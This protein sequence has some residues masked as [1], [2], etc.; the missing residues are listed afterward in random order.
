MFNNWNNRVLGK[1]K[2]V[3]FALTLCFF[4]ISFGA[5]ADEFSITPGDELRIFIP[6]LQ[7][8]EQLY[9]VGHQG[10]IDLGI[11]GKVVLAGYS[12]KNAQT[13]LR[14]HMSKY[15]KSVAGLTLMVKQS[16]RTILITGCVENPGLITIEST[17]DLWQALQLNDGLSGCA[18][19][20]RV[21]MLRNGLELE[22]NVHAFLTRDSIEPL[23]VLRA[24]DT[25]FVPAQAG[26]PLA[27]S[28]EHAF[29][30]NKALD[31]KVFVIGSVT[32][33]GMFDRSEALDVLTAVSLAGGPLPVADLA[34]TTLLTKDASIKID[35]QKAIAGK[36]LKKKLLP[37]DGAAIIYIPSLTENVDTRLGSHINVIG[38]FE[39]TGRI[40]VSG[41]IKLIDALGIV[42]GPGDDA[43][44]H[45]LRII[46]EGL[47]YTLVSRYDIGE[48]LEGGGWIGRVMVKPGSTIMMGR[49]NMQA[50]ATTTSII[51][52]LA[53][54]S[55][56]MALWLSLTGTIQPASQD[57]SS[58][59]TTTGE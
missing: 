19:L 41:P 38:P 13:I 6:G 3:A 12:V 9:I 16:K 48:Y 15:L 11:H 31:R 45:K 59:N 23:P 22:V 52:S 40:P 58:G 49:R 14:K 37:G 4:V 2:I 36:K 35:L 55:T 5:K 25:I 17:A 44:L 53:V 26:L 51:G 43:K 39:R 57:S 10:D 29:L 34:H 20:T 28:A 42:G 1:G 32:S 33:P 47:G 50:L 56:A 18:D 27:P 8:P 54:V 21:L 7:P 24:G 30:S 46:E